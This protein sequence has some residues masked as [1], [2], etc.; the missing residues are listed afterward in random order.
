MALRSDLLLFADAANFSLE[1][2]LNLLGEFNLLRT[3]PGQA[4]VLVGKLVSRF[5]ASIAD[6]GTPHRFSIRILDGNSALVATSP[7][8]PVHLGP[9]PIP[10]VPPRGVIIMDLPP[11]ALPAPDSYT[12]EVY[13]DGHRQELTA[14][15]H[16]VF[17]R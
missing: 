12:V 1:G 3:T 14:E 2:K 4:A 9:S 10:G 16:T 7:D 13:L 15:F 11:L 17:V 6:V 5:T 8:S